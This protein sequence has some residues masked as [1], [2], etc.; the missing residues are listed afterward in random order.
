MDK[1]IFTIFCAAVLFTA[2][3]DPTKRPLTKAD[4]IAEKMQSELTVSNPVGPVKKNVAD[5]IYNGELIERYA[6]GVIYKKGLIQNGL[7]HG[8][9]M[10]FYEN[11]QKW[12]EGV[13]NQGI[14]EGAGVSWWANG[15]VS[16][17]GN[18]KQGKM[19]GKWIFSDE[20]GSVVEKDFGGE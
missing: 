20:K 17:K 11:G 5:S 13:Y 3:G 14:R 12:S 10:T 16:S 6:S 9:W 8:I 19:V 15:V 2:C 4:S 18:Y 7:A 1:S